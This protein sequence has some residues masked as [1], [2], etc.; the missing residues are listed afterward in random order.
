MHDGFDLDPNDPGVEKAC[1]WT[2]FVYF[3]RFGNKY[4]TQLCGESYRE[5]N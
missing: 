2:K 3:E 1:A 4:K 5:M